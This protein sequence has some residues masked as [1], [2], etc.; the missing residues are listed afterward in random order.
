MSKIIVSTNELAAFFDVS[1]QAVYQWSRAGCPKVSRGKWDLKQVLT[2]WLETVYAERTAQDDESLSEI[3]RR[4]WSWKSENERMKAQQTETELIPKDQV[5]KQWA[6]RMAE[7][8]NGCFNLE[9]ALPPLLEGKDQPE[10]R[11]VIYDY[12]WDM[13]DRV[14]RTGQFTP[15]CSEKEIQDADPMGVQE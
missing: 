3:K 12:V 11:R 15:K 9:N 10:M 7:Y 5:H 6:S 4:Y 14:C 1:R 8:K 13:F 2:W